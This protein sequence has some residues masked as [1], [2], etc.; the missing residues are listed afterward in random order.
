[1]RYKVHIENLTDKTDVIDMDADAVMVFVGK[2]D[3]E[4]GKIEH[5]MG[6][7]GMKKVMTEVINAIPYQIRSLLQE[8]A[9]Q[10]PQPEEPNGKTK[11]ILPNDMGKKVSS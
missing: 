11:I 9:R 1:M 2:I 7:A 10:K 4:H 5:G 6:F 3:T 8:E